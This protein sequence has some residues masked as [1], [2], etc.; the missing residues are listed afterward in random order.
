MTSLTR[1]ARILAL[2]VFTAMLSAQAPVDMP[3]EREPRL[4]G[5]KS[6]KE[7]ILK[8]DHKKNLEDAA[9]LL[10]LAQ[11]L[12]SELDKSDRN[13]LPLSALRKAEDIEKLAR[14]IRGRLRKF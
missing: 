7:E 5:Q 8:L 11:G 2:A 4:P 9:R 12:K 6:Q 13:V 3:E 10:E 14:S 1:C